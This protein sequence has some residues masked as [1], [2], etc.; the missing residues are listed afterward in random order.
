MDLG[1]RSHR[2][3]DSH[4][5]VCSGSLNFHQVVPNLVLKVV[6]IM[7]R[8]RRAFEVFDDLDRDIAEFIEPR[9]F[10]RCDQFLVPWPRGIEPKLA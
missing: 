1:I 2:V 8:A 4:T 9:V 5:P 6:G 7:C 10:H 3:Q